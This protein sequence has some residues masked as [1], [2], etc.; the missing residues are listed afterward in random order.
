[1]TT[2]LIVPPALVLIAGGLLLPFVRGA[3]RPAALLLP[4]LVTLWLIWMLPE[5]AQLNAAVPRLRADG[6]QGR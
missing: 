5:G 1:M 4:P 2:S 6:C 3:A